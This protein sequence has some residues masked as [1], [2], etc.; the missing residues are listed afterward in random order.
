VGD[1]PNSLNDAEL[2]RGPGRRPWYPIKNVELVN[3]GRAHSIN[4]DRIHDC[5]GMST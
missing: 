3:L 4:N 2:I 5:L 1:T